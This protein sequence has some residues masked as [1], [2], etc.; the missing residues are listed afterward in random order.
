MRFT[1]EWWFKIISTK[2][3][4]MCIFFST[5]ITLLSILSHVVH[6]DYNNDSSPTVRPS[7]SV[8][9]TSFTLTASQAYKWSRYTYYSRLTMIVTASC[10]MPQDIS[11]ELHLRS[12]R[13]IEEDLRTLQMHLHL[14]FDRASVRF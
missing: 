12:Q 8:A 6:A 5:V 11:A 9:P 2:Q 13:S 14:R 10:F 1:Y 4:F 3:K 7:R